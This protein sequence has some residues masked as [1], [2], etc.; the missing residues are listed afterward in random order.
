MPEHSVLELLVSLLFCVLLAVFAYWREILDTKG[1]A[2]AF[3]IGIIIAIFGNIYWLI[4]LICFLI[5][6]YIVTKLD[7]S[8][9][10]TYGLAQGKKGERNAT[11]VLANGSIPAVIAVFSFQLGYPLAGL[12]FICSV[13][14]PA[15]DSFA[16]EIGV[17]SNKTY[18]I[19]K[20]SKRV[21]PG[22]DGGVSR[23]GQAAAF[24]G[25]LIPAL[26]GWVLISEYNNNIF[27]VT[28][29]EQMPM[30]FWTIAIPV[31]IGFIGCQID[32]ILG[33]TLQQRKLISN[34]GVN[35]FSILIGILLTVIIYLLIPI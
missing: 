24:I 10:Q 14:I 7:F 20:L 26:L 15:S 31:I 9:K 2:L 3:V 27:S 6:T 11:N 17:L 33:A 23:L 35:F 32:S 8:Y 28:T 4:T 16:N 18:L 29:Q 34:D 25:A 5:V 22:T 1:A 21:R 19:T 13:C 30:T 12:L